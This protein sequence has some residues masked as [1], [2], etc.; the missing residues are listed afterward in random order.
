MSAIGRGLRNPFRNSVRTAV[1]VLLLAVIIGLFAVMVQAAFQA[2]EQLKSLQANVRTLIELR[3]A[4]AFGTGGFGGD[5][6]VGE[7]DFSVQTLEMIKQI[8]H[9]KHIKKIEE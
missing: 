3:E 7:K 4:G 8:P 6:P 1:V 5:R 2:R 9:A